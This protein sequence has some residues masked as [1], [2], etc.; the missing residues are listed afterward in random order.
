MPPFGFRDFGAL[1]A[2]GE[3]NA[4]GW[5]G[6]IGFFKGGFIQGLVRTAEPRPALSQTSAVVARPV[7]RTVAMD[8][9]KHQRIGAAQDPDQLTCLVMAN[10]RAHER[11]TLNRFRPNSDRSLTSPR[12]NSATLLPTVISDKT[13]NQPIVTKRQGLSLPFETT[14]RPV[15]LRRLA[16]QRLHLN[17]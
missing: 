7:A 16:G 12:G 11:V 6:R 5:L 8:G 9:R 10:G 14:L 17:L 15:T 2:L 3:Y 1:V 4:Y 13:L